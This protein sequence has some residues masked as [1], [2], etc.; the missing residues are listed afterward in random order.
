MSLYKLG[1][2]P[3]LSWPLLVEEF[4]TTWLDREL[5]PLATRYL[6]RW[7]GLACSLNTAIFFLPQK[8]GGL[9]LPSLTCL[10]KK[11]QSI[12]MVQL[13]LSDDPCP[14]R[15]SSIYYTCSWRRREG[16]GLPPE[17][18]KFALNASLETLA[19]NHNL[20]VWSKKSSS[21]CTLCSGH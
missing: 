19:T 2:C 10:H 13:F 17:A 5:Q 16:Q 12:R 8:R 9:G 6:K 14:L 1:V 20:H 3:H 15:C 11:Q 18:V 4:P 7:S 21:T